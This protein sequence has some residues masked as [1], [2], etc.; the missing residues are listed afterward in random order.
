MTTIKFS[1][2]YDF[3]RI[4]A[5]HRPI[6][7]VTQKTNISSESWSYALTNPWQWVNEIKSPALNKQNQRKQK[8]TITTKKTPTSEKQTPNKQT[9]KTNRFFTRK[10]CGDKK[11]VYSCYWW[12]VLM[13]NSRY[14]VLSY[15][16]EHI[17][18]VEILVLS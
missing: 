16:D 8:Q 17:I 5:V 1:K 7:Y 6:H 9:N 3:N 10:Y 2:W 13:N 4:F 18:R 15:Y 12:Y 11:K 14:T